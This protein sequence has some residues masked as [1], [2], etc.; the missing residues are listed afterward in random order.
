MRSMFG[1][2]GVMALAGLVGG[3]GA[4]RHSA[5]ES[6]NAAGSSAGGDGSA[7]G[8]TAEELSEA[9][10]RLAV[11]RCDKITGCSPA[12]LARYGT[13]ADAGVTSCVGVERDRCVD[14]FSAVAGVANSVEAVLAAAPTTC[15]EALDTNLPY[16]TG[17]QGELARGKACTWNE[18]CASGYCARVAD[19]LCG[20]C[21]FVPPGVEPQTG[22]PC[23]EGACPT[24]LACHEQICKQ[25]PG[26]GLPCLQLN[27]RPSPYDVCAAGL[28]C[29]ASTCVTPL[30]FGDACS[31]DD[32]RCD[33]RH[34]LVCKGGQCDLAAPFNVEGPCGGFPNQGSCGSGDTCVYPAD[35]NLG[36]D[37][38]PGECQPIR[39][40]FGAPCNDAKDC[41]SGM[42]CVPS[43]YAGAA[44]DAGN[45]AFIGLCGSLPVSISCE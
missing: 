24:P 17:A 35:Y 42:A 45:V 9:C 27:E 25:P 2:I 30:F 37:D 36:T 11:S 16:R 33:V 43:E 23:T 8:P 7:D 14:W 22:Q 31:T 10:T 20:S 39:T 44:A 21:D 13:S 1:L 38:R 3:C 28:L 41:P 15:A 29:A 5:D 12:D 19:A 26:E 18:Q 32:D 34:G 6:E 40:G 4:T